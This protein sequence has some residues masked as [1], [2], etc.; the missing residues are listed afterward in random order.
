MF[1]VHYV[2]EMDGGGQDELLC[3]YSTYIVHLNSLVS[4]VGDTLS[5][6]SGATV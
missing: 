5:G 1:G 3:S 4:H 2:C 6:T